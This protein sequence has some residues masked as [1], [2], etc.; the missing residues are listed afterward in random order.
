MCPAPRALVETRSAERGRGRVHRRRPSTT[1]RSSGLRSGELRALR[2]GEV[3]LDAGVIR[4]RAGWDD[5][6]GE[7]EPK[8]RS[9]ERVVPI[10]A[11]LRPMLLA[12][13]MATG[14]RGKPGALV[15]G[16]GDADPFLRSTPRA[17]ARKAWT[18]A[19]LEPI[20]MHEARHSYASMMVAA[21]VD[22]GEVMRRMGHSTIAIDLDRYTHGL[23]GSEADTA[24]SS[25][26]SS[27]VGQS[28]DSRH[29]SWAFPS[30]PGR[31][32]RDQRKRRVSRQDLRLAG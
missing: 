11:D 14:R 12:H 2:V 21:G 8:S 20:T 25:R 24:A 10:I 9:G 4:V 7:I 29:P 23:R 30:G 16:R 6:E 26:R 17:R 28:W 5:V 15:F 3:D 31:C 27:T 32:A 13:L 1:G 18:T 19:G 22:P